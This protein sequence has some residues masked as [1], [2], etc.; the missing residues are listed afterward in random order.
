MSRMKLGGKFV[1]VV[2]CFEEVV[3]KSLTSGHCSFATVA[4]TVRTTGYGHSCVAS[5][6]LVIQ[7]LL[8]PAKRVRAFTASNQAIDF[9]KARCGEQTGYVTDTI[10]ASSRGD[11]GFMT[12]VDQEG[13]EH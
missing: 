6:N 4:L 12:R 3:G 10:G 9:V 7:P 8:P 2:E 11:P 1:K 5:H 13:A